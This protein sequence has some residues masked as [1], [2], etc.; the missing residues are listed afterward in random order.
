MVYVK[1]KS[2]IGNNLIFVVNVTSSG[3]FPL[4]TRLARSKMLTASH[5]GL[6]RLVSV[7][8]TKFSLPMRAPN[9]LD[10][11]LAVDPHLT[12]YARAAIVRARCFGSAS[13]T[14]FR[15]PLA[16]P[17]AREATKSIGPEEG[18]RRCTEDTCLS[19]CRPCRFSLL[20]YGVRAID[21]KLLPPS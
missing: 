5:I 2:P 19:S 4:T 13:P 12:R 3:H 17:S 7:F 14:N 1:N 6:R 15:Q 11:S 9:R 20:C 21:R 10:R 16:F 18:F 8:L